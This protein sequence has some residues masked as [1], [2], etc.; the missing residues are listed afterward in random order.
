MAAI[1]AIVSAN[2]ILLG[3]VIVTILEE[4]KSN[5]TKEALNV[6]PEEDRKER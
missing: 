3:Y 4:K 2:V 5:S 1:T 6:P